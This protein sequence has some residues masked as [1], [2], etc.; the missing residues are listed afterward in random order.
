MDVPRRLPKEPKMKEKFTGAHTLG[1][2]VAMESVS[3]E[4]IKELCRGSG[5][6][7]KD[8]NYPQVKKLEGKLAAKK[9]WCD[10]FRVKLQAKVKENDAMRCAYRSVIAHAKTI[11]KKFKDV[12]PVETCGEEDV[13]HGM[14]NMKVIYNG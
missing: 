2:Y 12:L 6:I 14:D 1:R 4:V 7:V 10:L 9:R 3:T 8:V 13:P 11:C 5:V